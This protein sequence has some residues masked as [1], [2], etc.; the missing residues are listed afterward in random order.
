MIRKM[1]IGRAVA[2]AMHLPESPR[3]VPLKPG[4]LTFQG[5]RKGTIAVAQQAQ[6]RLDAG[7][8]R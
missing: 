1:A 8:T 6:A 5:E 7:A 3:Q 2:D 4:V